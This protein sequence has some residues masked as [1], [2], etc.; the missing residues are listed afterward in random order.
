MSTSPARFGSLVSHPES[1]TSRFLIDNFCMDTACSSLV[2]RLPR[3]RPSRRAEAGPPSIFS[4]RQIPELELPVSHRKQKIGPFSNRHKFAF[5]NFR[6]LP[7]RASLHP[8]ILASSPLLIANDM[9][10]REESSISKQSTYEFLIAN[11]I[12]CRAN[13]HSASSS[14]SPGSQF[15]PS[16]PKQ[17]LQ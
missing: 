17:A 7:F 8:C 9:H 11:E 5:C 2:T 14:A 12:H 16:S 3:R 15:T 4:N 1:T 6:H 13:P 10:S